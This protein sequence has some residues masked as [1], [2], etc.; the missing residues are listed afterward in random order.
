MQKFFIVNQIMA[1]LTMIAETP[2]GIPVP[3]LMVELPVVEECIK[4]GKI[5]QQKRT[6]F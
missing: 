3:A 1:L 2:M 4:N 6:S 5:H